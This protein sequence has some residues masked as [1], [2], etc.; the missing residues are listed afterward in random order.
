MHI[1]AELLLTVKR[2]L[3]RLQLW[4]ST[5]FLKDSRLLHIWTKIILFIS[6]CDDTLLY[7]IRYNNLLL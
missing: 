5:I 6:Y 1:I 7:H 3:K 4:Y 2:A